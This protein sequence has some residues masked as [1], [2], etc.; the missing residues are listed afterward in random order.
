[1]YKVTNQ[2]TRL[3]SAIDNA[4]GLLPDDRT[5]LIIACEKLIESIKGEH[6]TSSCI[7]KKYQAKISCLDKQLLENEETLSNLEKEVLGT[8]TITTE[9]INKICIL[10]QNISALTYA[11]QTLETQ[12]EEALSNI[13]SSSLTN[14]YK[15]TLIDGNQKLIET[16]SQQIAQLQEQNKE[17]IKV[18]IDIS[19]QIKEQVGKIENL[20]KE[21]VGLTNSKSNDATKMRDLCVADVEL[22]DLEIEI[23]R[24]LN[25]NTKLLKVVKTLKR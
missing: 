5:D 4:T 19:E 22:L 23:D 24:L 16:K 7:I 10:E 17:L 12:L 3:S 13:T 2:A 20:D 21:L 6:E 15:Q 14:T 11:N 25:E 8:K 1:M 18:I 9:Q